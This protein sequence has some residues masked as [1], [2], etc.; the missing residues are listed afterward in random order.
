MSQLNA[1]PHF[2]PSKDKEIREL[3]EYCMMLYR[4]L[5]QV[6][7]N[8]DSSNFS[9]DVANTLNSVSAIQEE[10]EVT[11]KEYE[12]MVIRHNEE[13]ANMVLRPYGVQCNPTKT[14]SA[15]E[16]KRQ[17]ALFGIEAMDYEGPYLSLLKE[18]YDGSVKVINITANDGICS[19]PTYGRPK[20][21]ATKKPL[22]IDEY[23]FFCTED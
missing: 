12:G 4:Q 21:S 19:T 15:Y 20:L 3:Q 11:T 7:A 14:V 5:R 9:D 1:M 22:Y 17:V 16:D 6:L 10:T 2:S 18:L 8:L 23:G 13:S